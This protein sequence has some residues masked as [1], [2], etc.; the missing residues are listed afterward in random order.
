MNRSLERAS[1]RLT[2][3]CGITEKFLVEVYIDAAGRLDSIYG[4]KEGL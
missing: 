3:G 2:P 4:T 1:A